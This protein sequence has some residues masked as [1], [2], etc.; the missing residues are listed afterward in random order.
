[1]AEQ[2]TAANLQDLV[3]E[4]IE[5]ITI[6]IE[7]RCKNEYDFVLEEGDTSKPMGW[8]QMITKRA[9]NG[10]TQATCTLALNNTVKIINESGEEQ[11]IPK[12]TFNQTSPEE[13]FA[14]IQ[15]WWNTNVADD[16]IIT[17]GGSSQRY[18]H[19]IWFT[20]DWSEA[21]GEDKSLSKQLMDAI[22]GYHQ[23]IKDIYFASFVNI[24]GT[25]ENPSGAYWLPTLLYE[26]RN[27][28]NVVSLSYDL[29][30]P[31]EALGGKAQPEVETV[32]QLLVQWWK[33]KDLDFILSFDQ[34]AT[35][36][37]RPELLHFSV[38]WNK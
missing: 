6:A 33:E 25:E 13:V 7:A 38:T 16:Y 4:Y 27:G 35:F 36:S 26:A 20:V 10:G 1:M 14:T 18:E 34:I 15:N 22:A 9:Q 11:E 17:F 24:Y 8:A 12:I 28:K 31:I 2:I 3:K 30:S 23:D 29:N 19:S 37:D 32:K 21:E 5:N